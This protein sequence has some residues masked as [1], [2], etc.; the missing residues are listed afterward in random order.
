MFNI[1][2]F[3]NNEKSSFPWLGLS[4]FLAGGKGGFDRGED[5]RGS[6][7]CNLLLTV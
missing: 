3:W 6:K 7:R 5:G 2:G 4:R 1:L